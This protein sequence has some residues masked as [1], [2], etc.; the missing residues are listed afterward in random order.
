MN[1]YSTSTS[2][3]G[4]NWNIVYDSNVQWIQPKAP[5]QQ[6]F[7]TDYAFVFKLLEALLKY[8]GVAVSN[9]YDLA[10]LLDKLQEILKMQKDLYGI[11]VSEQAMMK[12]AKCMTFREL[13]DFLKEPEEDDFENEFGPFQLEDA[14]DR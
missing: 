6:V 7:V 14:E 12:I 1:Y 10:L 9:S 3:T 8:R 4:G 5:P 13:D 2:T 11:G